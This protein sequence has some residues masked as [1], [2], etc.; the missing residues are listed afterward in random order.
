MYINEM[1]RGERRIKLQD[2]PKSKLIIDNQVIN[3]MLTKWL[4]P[5][6]NANKWLGSILKY[7]EIIDDENIAGINYSESSMSVNLLLKNAQAVSLGFKPGD[8][9]DYPQLIIRDSS[10]ARVYDCDYIASED[11]FYIK[12]SNVKC[13][14]KASSIGQYNDTIVFSDKLNYGQ[15]IIG[16]NNDE[17]DLFIHPYKE[18]IRAYFL[19]LSFPAN[20][21]DIYVFVTKAVG[22]PKTYN[23]FKLEL[24]RRLSASEEVTTDLI[25][26]MG[27]KLVSYTKTGQNYIITLLHS[28]LVDLTYTNLANLEPA[29]INRVTTLSTDNVGADY[30]FIKDLKKS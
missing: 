20:I 1:F 6:I 7:L 14:N 15:L 18:F 2:M 16:L 9:E 28:G 3:N 11:A 10:L 17:E 22:N 19:N 24:G 23:F 12:L 25:K 21:N 29:T 13:K 8:Q 4:S 26:F 5:N 27:G 30:Q